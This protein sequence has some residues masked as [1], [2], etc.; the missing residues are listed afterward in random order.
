MERGFK[1]EYGCCLKAHPLA[2]A[3]LTALSIPYKVRHSPNIINKA[4]RNRNLHR[5]S[6]DA[7]ERARLQTECGGFC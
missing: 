2:K 7:E 1:A 4:L 3:V 5:F 6:L